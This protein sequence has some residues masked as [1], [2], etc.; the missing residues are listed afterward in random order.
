[1]EENVLC[2]K[3]GS[4]QVYLDGSIHATICRGCYA[5]GIRDQSTDDEVRQALDS[6][7]LKGAWDIDNAP[8]TYEEWRDAVIAERHQRPLAF[9]VWGGG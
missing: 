3:C 5:I 9:S 6:S 2:P 8:Q 7:F 4:T 1:M